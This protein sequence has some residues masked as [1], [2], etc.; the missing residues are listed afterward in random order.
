MITG[1]GEVFEFHGVTPISGNLLYA[2]HGCYLLFDTFIQ[3]HDNLCFI[4]CNE[5]KRD[6]KH[7]K[8]EVANNFA[9]KKNKINSYRDNCL[10]LVRYLK[11]I[12]LTIPICNCIVF[13]TTVR[14]YRSSNYFPDKM[15][16]I[17]NLPL[18]KLVHDRIEFENQWNRCQKCII[19]LM[20]KKLSKKKVIDRIDLIK[21]NLVE[22]KKRNEILKQYSN[23]M[24]N[25][26]SI[27]T[28]IEQKYHS[29]LSGN[30]KKQKK[31]TMSTY[32]LWN[33]ER[34]MK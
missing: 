6:Q 30:Q 29:F 31:K 34:R 23:N 20:E 5:K 15:P 19:V 25:T 22:L 1:E 16:S 7:E 33:E 8:N 14:I 17:E 32:E 4:N 28:T 24:Y 12:A 21:R 18:L 9:E 2:M 10:L 27:V 11:H 26:D 13:Y 3:L